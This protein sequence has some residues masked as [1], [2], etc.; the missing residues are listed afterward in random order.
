MKVQSEQKVKLAKEKTDR[1]ANFEA[2]DD[3]EDS[4]N[5]IGM[6]WL[7]RASELTCWVGEG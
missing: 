6:R 7:L 2:G 4:N 3:G 5:L 1:E